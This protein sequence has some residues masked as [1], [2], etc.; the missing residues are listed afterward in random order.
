MRRLAFF[1]IFLM[2]VFVLSLK[3]DSRAQDASTGAIRGCVVD[4]DGKRIVGASVTL[5]NTSNG[6]VASRTTNEDGRFGFELLTPGEYSARAETDGM[7]PQVAPQIHV[8]VG[9]AIDLELRLGLAGNKETVT[10]RSIVSKPE[11]KTML[12]TKLVQLIKKI[13]SLAWINCY[14]EA[15]YR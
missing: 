7:S 4:P 9:G 15:S 14:C 10:V 2:L 5:V 11:L 12:I 3:T 1:P 6:M 13:L 8:E